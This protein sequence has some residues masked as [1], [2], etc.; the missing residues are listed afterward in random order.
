MNIQT[1]LSRVAPY[2][3]E[4]SYGEFA[5][6]MENAYTEISF[7]GSRRV[8]SVGYKGS[9]SL[10]DIFQKMNDLIDSHPHFN[11]EE[12]KIGKVIEAKRDMLYHISYDQE[13]KVNFI[14]SFFMGVVNLFTPK[15][16][17][18]YDRWLGSRSFERYTA[19]QYVENFNS[20][21][22]DKPSGYVI[23]RNPNKGLPVYWA[24]TQ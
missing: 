3:A 10:E 15:L 4:T 2:N 14:T 18:I 5:K 17:Q 24:P 22:K 16:D 20:E 12:R 6:V 1:A 8:Y 21:P 7:W 11:E 9:V 19:K 13:E 23:D